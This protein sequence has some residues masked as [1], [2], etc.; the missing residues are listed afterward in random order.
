MKHVNP[1]IFPLCNHIMHFA[2]IIHKNNV[3]CL[4]SGRT[5]KYGDKDTNTYA[6]IMT[7]L[8][9]HVKESSW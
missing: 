2:Q 6:N 9:I 4:S 3:F 7:D 1:E 8:L 5:E